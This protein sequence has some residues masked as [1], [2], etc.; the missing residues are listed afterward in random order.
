MGASARERAPDQT[1]QD[2]ADRL[3]LPLGRVLDP[4]PGER[5]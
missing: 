5:E 4:V 3:G 2:E 1:L